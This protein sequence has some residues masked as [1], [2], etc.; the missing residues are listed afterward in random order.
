LLS[1]ISKP[2][3]FFKKKIT[4]VN[5]YKRKKSNVYALERLKETHNYDYSAFVANYYK[6]Q[7][8]TVWEY[9]KEKNVPDN[10][11]NLVIKK[12]ADI[13]LVQCKNNFSEISLANV[14]KFENEVHEFLSQ[15]TLF[16]S[17]DLR[18]CYVLP[19][20]QFDKSA[21]NY[22]ANNHNINYKILKE[23]AL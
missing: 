20:Y 23:H 17:Y 6:K 9:S 13:L 11:I 4:A 14:I 15:H 1:I 3:N 2:L 21:S 5:F 7:N 18:Y 8:Y 10:E 16:Q 12:E 22:I 19:K